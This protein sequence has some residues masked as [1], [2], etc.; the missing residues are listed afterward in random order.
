LKDVETKHQAIVLY[1]PK[2][3]KDEFFIIENRWPDDTYDKKLPDAGLAVWH[4]I[5]NLNRY[6]KLAKP[7][8]VTPEMWKSITNPDDWGRSCVRLIRAVTL[9]NIDDRKVLF[10]SSQPETGYDLLDRDE[11][12]TYSTLT[13][14]DGTP[15]GFSLLQI[16]KAGPV[17]RFYVR[18]ADA[19]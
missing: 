1:D 9:P 5:E 16:P 11:N 17:M 6:E 19:K 15:S 3:G 10:D 7:P 8:Q 18:K 2:H 4:I 12:P 13:W 14:A